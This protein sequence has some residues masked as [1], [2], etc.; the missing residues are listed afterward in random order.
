VA[1]LAAPLAVLLAGAL[2]AAPAPGPGQAPA[3]RLA[4]TI[5]DSALEGARSLPAGLTEIQV[6]N[7]GRALHVVQMFAVPEAHTADEVRTALGRGQVP[8]WLV[9]AVGI[10][11]V[12]AGHAASLTMILQ[13]G[14]YVL[15]DDFPGADRRP[16]F[17]HGVMH[18]VTVTGRTVEDVANLPARTGLLVTPRGFRFGQILRRGDTWTLVEGRNRTTLFRPGP[19]VMRIETPAR[20]PLH[21]IVI[22][23]GEPRDMREYG[24]WLDGR[25]PAPP[26][27][28][29]T[30]VPGIPADTRVFLDFPVTTGI[31]TVFCP[32]RHATGL[33]G[34]ETGEFTQ[35]AVR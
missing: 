18:E 15:L 5:T 9:P 25:R 24:E 32:L 30:G 35:F 7:R 1:R 14:Q 19:M 10:G 21:S 2:G 34:F 13:P 28:V 3:R 8:R 33:R 22:I 23:R 11:P 20:S 17:T 27:G 12:E 4:L 29:V 26:E 6:T 16:F 31:Y